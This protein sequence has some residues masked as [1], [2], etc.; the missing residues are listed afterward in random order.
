MCEEYA[1]INLLMQ[2]QTF[3]YVQYTY[4]YILAD[5]NTVCVI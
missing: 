4:V 5:R 3:T 1:C 2:M